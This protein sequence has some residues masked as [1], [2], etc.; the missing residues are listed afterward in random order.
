[1]KILKSAIAVVTLFCLITA[2]FGKA[3]G[4]KHV[5]GNAELRAARIESLTKIWSKG[6]HNA[7]TDLIWYHDKWYCVFRESSGH[8]SEDG[9]IRLISSKDGEN[10]AEAKLFK[11]SRYDLRD[12]K[13]CITPS[14]KLMLHYAGISYDSVGTQLFRNMV[15]F[16]TDGKQWSKP[17]TIEVDSQMAWRITWYK[18]IAYTLAW[19]SVYGLYLYNSND[20]I[21]FKRIYKFD[22]K[23]MPNEATIVFDKNGR[24]TAI[25]R[26]DVAPKSF[27][28]GRADYP[29]TNWRFVENAEFA[30]GPNMIYVN[31]STLVAA[32][33]IYD[34][35][36]GKTV[37]YKVE[38]YNT[39]ELLTL[40][41]GGDNG[42]AGMCLRNDTLW[43][44]YY[45]SQ[46]GKANIYLA[47][48][49]FS[50]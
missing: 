23:G 47:K 17:K 12:P 36:K 10:W 28:M 34:N 6:Q 26:K 11:D 45:S 1:M 38:D 40:P 20:G 5:S 42:Y 46:E 29:Y 24:M 43:M 15:H 41:S 44:S 2:V 18:G 35:G 22:L 9:C 30:G 25:I 4:L 21:H 50:K 37:L 3:P 14:G 32:Y 27:Y 48:V 13:L 19:N 7:F 16:S 31:D 8:Q 33:R 39:T 49:S